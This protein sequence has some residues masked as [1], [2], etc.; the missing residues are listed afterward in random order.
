MT[1][2]CI[3]KVVAMAP[4]FLAAFSA[5]DCATARRKTVQASMRAGSPI[6]SENA[7]TMRSAAR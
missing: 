7:A 5:S 2:R 6:S 4:T 1:I 3:M